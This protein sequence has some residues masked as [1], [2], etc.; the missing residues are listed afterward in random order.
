MGGG[1]GIKKK[2][3]GREGNRKRNTS[4]CKAMTKVNKKEEKVI[5]KRRR[6]GR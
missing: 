1:R 5:E 6:K 4:K 3:K 2:T